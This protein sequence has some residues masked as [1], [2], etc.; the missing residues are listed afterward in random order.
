LLLLLACMATPASA[1][2]LH[3]MLQTTNN[4]TNNTFSTF[5]Q[6]TVTSQWVLM[7]HKTRAT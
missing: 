6:S 3:V 7:A 5:N 2:L 1:Q 4:N